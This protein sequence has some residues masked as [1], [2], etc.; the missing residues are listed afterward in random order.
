MKLRKTFFTES[1]PAD[2]CLHG[3]SHAQVTDETDEIIIEQGNEHIVE[4]AWLQL[5]RRHRELEKQ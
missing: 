2:C 1:V 5:R 3:I 4:P